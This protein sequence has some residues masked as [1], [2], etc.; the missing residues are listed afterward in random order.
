MSPF[1]ITP[2]NETLYFI[3]GDDEKQLTWVAAQ[4]P[5]TAIKKIILVNGNIKTTSDALNQ[6]IY[7]DQGGVLVNRFGIERLP[8][9]VDEMPNHSLL[10]I[11]EVAVK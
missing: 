11:T 3:D 1:D 2:F 8:S 4:K 5:T 10:R 9:V 7:F 6:R